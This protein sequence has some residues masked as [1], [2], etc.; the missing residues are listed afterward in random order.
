ISAGG[1]A[2][3][4]RLPLLG[5]QG[6]RER[7]LILYK[8]LEEVFI[9]EAADDA[10]SLTSRAAELAEMLG[11]AVSDDASKGLSPVEVVASVRR[12]L[13]VEAVS[14]MR[15]TLVPEFNVYASNLVDGLEHLRTGIVDAIS[16]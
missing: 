1:M 13:V 11:V 12:A 6:G 8:L 7:G 14:G 4:T 9:G 2:N 3:D 10:V 5:I 16:F 15:Q